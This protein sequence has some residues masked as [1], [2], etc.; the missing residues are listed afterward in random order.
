[1]KTVRKTGYYEVM[2]IFGDINSADV[3][4]IALWDNDEG[5]FFINGE[6]YEESAFSEIREFVI[7]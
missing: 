5:L 2:S 3:C 7:I 1:M 4:K 6:T